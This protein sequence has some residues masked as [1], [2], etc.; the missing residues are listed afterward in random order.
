MKMKSPSIFDRRRG[1]ALLCLAAAI[2]S[3]GTPAIAQHVKVFDLSGTVLMALA[4]QDFSYDDYAPL[5]ASLEAAGVKVRVAAG[6][7]DP[8]V[9]LRGDPAEVAKP[10]VSLTDANAK[11]AAG[12]VFV[13]GWGASSYQYAFAGTYANTAYRPDPTVA[14]AVSR[15]IGDMLADGARGSRGACVSAFDMFS[16]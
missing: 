2:L 15:L 9:P 5:R 6:S 13:G 14:K 8:C 12:I 3:R 10:D 7:L 11:E 16:P 4:N 1:A